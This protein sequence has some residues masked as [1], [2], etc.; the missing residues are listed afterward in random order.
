V[1]RVNPL[2]QLASKPGGGLTASS[3]LQFLEDMVDV[4]FDRGLVDGDAAGNFLIGEALFEQY[5]N[6]HL[7]PGQRCRELSSAV[8]PGKHPEWL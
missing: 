4:A 5:C 2:K 3:D 1:G 6:L 8:R 7:A